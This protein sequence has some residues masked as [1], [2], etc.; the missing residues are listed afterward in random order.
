MINKQLITINEDDYSSSES[1]EDLQSN[2]T[3]QIVVRAD[4]DEIKQKYNFRLE[5]PI[6]VADD[7]HI[8]LEILKQHTINLR[9]QD[10]T[11]FCVNG[12]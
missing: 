1:S 9:V 7:Q 3:N 8:N 10:Q 5:G 6:I 11:I 2:N 4:T 12:Q